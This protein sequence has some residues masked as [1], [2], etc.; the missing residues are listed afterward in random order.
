MAFSVVPL[1]DQIMIVRA[2]VLLTVLVF[3]FARCP[4]N[5]AARGAAMGDRSV[6]NSQGIVEYAWVSANE[7]VCFRDEQHTVAIHKEISGGRETELPALSAL[8]SESI[9]GG[10]DQKNVIVGVSPDEKWLLWW[11]PKGGPSDFHTATLDGKIHRQWRET[12]AFLSPSWFGEGH[13]WLFSRE[14]NILPNVNSPS[15]R[16]V[17]TLFDPDAPEALKNIPVEVKTEIAHGAPIARGHLCYAFYCLFQDPAFIPINEYVAT[18]VLYAFDQA[19][20][21]RYRLE[22][23]VPFRRGL[24][25]DPYAVISPACESLAWLR[26]EPNENRIGIWVSRLDGTDMRR[27]TDLPAAGDELFLH[28]VVQKLRWA[29]DGKRLSFLHGDALHTIDVDPK[30]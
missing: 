4:L 8:L 1:E 17:L 29:N 12:G 9:A 25:L 11:V 27:I 22:A 16:A 2:S 30:P 28:S 18:G 13:R 7:V 5:S 14:N 15:S 6:P 26:R 10:Q 23:V 3:T 24:T 20:A 21:T 19:G